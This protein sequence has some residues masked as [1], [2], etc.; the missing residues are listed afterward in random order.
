V[1]GKQQHPS[2]VYDE[3]GTLIGDYYADLLVD[4]VTE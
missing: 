2:A 3:G 4:W 1:D